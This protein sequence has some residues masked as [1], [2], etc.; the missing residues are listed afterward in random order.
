MLQHLWSSRAQRFDA[1][2]PIASPNNGDSP[3]GISVVAVSFRFGAPVWWNV[4][5]ELRMLKVYR[6]PKRWHQPGCRPRRVDF[7]KAKFFARV[8][9][10]K[11]LDSLEITC[12]FK[13]KS[14]S[15]PNLH[16][17]GFKVLIFEGCRCKHHLSIRK[18]NSS[19]WSRSSW[20]FCVCVC[21]GQNMSK[22]CVCG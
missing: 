7:W 2:F 21:V 6:G 16:D 12:F 19:P 8:G 18:V 9:R 10:W 5:L 15:E 17:F 11:V 22:R 13:G 14:Q 20:S 3:E 1:R 4:S